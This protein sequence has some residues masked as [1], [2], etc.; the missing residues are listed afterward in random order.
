MYNVG[1]KSLDSFIYLAAEK[2][3]DGFLSTVANA[4]D[5]EGHDVA[6]GNATI[7]DRLFS[8]GDVTHIQV[9]KPVDNEHNVPIIDLHRDSVTLVAK[10]GVKIVSWDTEGFVKRYTH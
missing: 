3:T 2:F 1:I 4:I 6:V 9:G 7:I 8:L 5:F 10:D